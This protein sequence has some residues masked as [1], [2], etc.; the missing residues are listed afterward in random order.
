MFLSIPNIKNTHFGE[1]SKGKNFKHLKRY[2]FQGNKSSLALFIQQLF[3]RY[4]ESHMK[5]YIGSKTI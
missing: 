5:L 1:K 2:G 3:Q 4:M